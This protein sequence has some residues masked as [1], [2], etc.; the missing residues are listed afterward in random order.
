MFT[1][2]AFKRFNAAA[3]TRNPG[4]A[5]TTHRLY[6]EDGHAPTGFCASFGAMSK[7]VT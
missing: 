1:Y 7:K 4:A 6:R 5:T 2:L 3:V